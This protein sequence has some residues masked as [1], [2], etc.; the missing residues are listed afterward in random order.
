M[1]SC[2]NAPAM[3]K[4]SLRKQLYDEIHSQFEARLR[5][6][7]RQNAELEEEIETR[8]QDR[9]WLARYTAL[10]AA[11]LLVKPL[12][13][14]DVRQRLQLAAQRRHTGLRIRAE[15]AAVEIS[16]V[17]LATVP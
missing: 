6:A 2:Y 5:E 15:T 11:D 17:M 9:G 13:P 1:S 3:D 12:N 16:G 7:R 10:G 8:L 14:T 4:D